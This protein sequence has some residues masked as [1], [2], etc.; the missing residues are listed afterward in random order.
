[1]NQKEIN[2]KNINK[3]TIFFTSLIVL[4]LIL[5]F[6]IAYTPLFNNISVNLS[7]ILSEGI[8]FV[9]TILFFVITKQN[10]KETVRLKSMHI[11]TY[12]IIPLLV[13]CITPII[14][15]VNA[16]SML[17]VKN[18]VSSTI[19]YVVTNNS[20][21]LTLG[22]MALMP[23]IVEE[24][25][26]RGV[27]L[28]N[29]R[30]SGALSGILMSGF[31]F[32]LMH[33]NFNQMAYAVLLGIIFGIVLEATGSIISTI[34]MHFCINGSSVLLSYVSQALFSG[35]DYQSVS[36]QGQLDAASLHT[37]INSYINILPYALVFSC[38]LIY[39]LAAINK[40]QENLINIFR[41]K[42]KSDVTNDNDKVSVFSPLLIIVIIFCL[43]RC[44][45]DEFV[46]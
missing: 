28:G 43:G 40:R 20:F 26:F 4:Y 42:K 21:L 23:A 46:L 8:L 41:L 2:K 13:F 27:I 39:S 14:T 17:F 19:T 34:E 30:Y 38:L 3:A 24:L 32:G 16:V 29:Y 25:A 7:L 18:Y 33:M 15:L 22:L 11:G 5:S 10:F 36:S 35:K 44:I 6:C 45:L 37:I 1:M 9:P 31:L 12:F